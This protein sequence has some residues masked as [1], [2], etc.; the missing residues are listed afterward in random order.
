MKWL[1]RIHASADLTSWSDYD[2]AR[3]YWTTNRFKSKKIIIP[4]SVRDPSQK[5]DAGCSVSIHF[6][7]KICTKSNYRHD[8][9]GTCNHNDTILDNSRKLLNTPFVSHQ[10]ISWK[11]CLWF[12]INILQNASRNMYLRRFWS[13]QEQCISNVNEGVVDCP[14]T[15][16]RVTHRNCGSASNSSLLGGKKP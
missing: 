3:G 1:F 15:H 2:I 10:T 14:S 16:V 4:G 11:T 13:R 7:T 6:T 5:I 8:G 12:C 9:E